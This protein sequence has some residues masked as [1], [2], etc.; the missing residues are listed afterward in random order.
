M[1]TSDPFETD[2]VASLKERKETEETLASV[3]HAG[4]AMVVATAVLLTFNS[5]GLQ[6]W[7]RNLDGNTMTDRWVTEADNWHNLMARLGF[8][9]PKDAVQT[10]IAEIR[11]IE[12]PGGVD[13][14][15][16]DEVDLDD[17]VDVDAQ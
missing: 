1:I 14:A 11:E 10:A 15:H 3:R 2:D 7:T 9:G 5:A 16:A 13:A 6:T 4:M 17:E 12:W 8:A